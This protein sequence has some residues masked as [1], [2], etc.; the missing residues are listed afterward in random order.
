[1]LATSPSQAFWGSDR[2]R[3]RLRRSESSNSSNVSVDI[4][5]ADESHKTSTSSREEAELQ[6]LNQSLQDL[7][8][9]FPDIQPE[10]FREMLATFSRESRLHVITEAL[11]KD[12]SKFVRNRWRVGPHTERCE[13][14][15]EVNLEHVPKHETF[16]SQ[17]Y[18]AAVK[19]A[20]YEEFNSLS[21]STIKTVLAERNHSYSE[22]RPIL[23]EIDAQSW[24]SALTRF[25]TR[26]KAQKASGNPFVVL[27]KSKAGVSEP[28]LKSV[29]CSELAEE[30]EES[31]VVPLRDAQISEQLTRDEH[32]AASINHQQA[33]ETGSLLECECC[34]DTV[35][36]EN[37]L[38][39]SHDDHFVCFTCVQRTLK[40]ALF[41]QGFA[42]SVAAETGTLRCFALAPE[43]TG[44][45]LGHLPPASVR[46]AIESQKGGTDIWLKFEHKL[47]DDNL[48]A[49]RID[50]LKCPFCPYAEA[51]ASTASES[52]D[53]QP[54][55]Y[56][57]RLLLFILWLSSACL[58]I[59]ENP[60][61]L[62]LTAM[63]VAFSLKLLLQD[64]RKPSRAPEGRKPRR[65][66]FMPSQG[67][68][69]TCRNPACQKIS[70]LRC[71]AV[72]RDIH[73]CYYSSK[74][75]LRT[76]VESAISNAVKRTCPLCGL[77]FVKASGCN[78][79]ACPC[80]YKMC[81]LC[82]ADVRESG[83]SH[84]CPHFRP[85][86]GACTVCTR[87]DLYKNEDEE[88]VVRQARES[89]EKEWFENEGRGLDRERLMD[90]D[91]V[92][93]KR[94]KG[95]P[96]ERMGESGLYRAFR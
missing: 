30:L 6:E 70:C 58:A 29:A 64:Y 20:L 69:F 33:Q 68:K 77:S 40:E 43:S 82:R 57:H 60:F 17:N 23:L 10:V 56:K 75:S 96:Y 81:Y 87:C 55:A 84:F 35:T 59:W 73:Q 31:F 89:A 42:Q 3:F 32:L 45:C 93:S 37:A 47:M 7:S 83:Y 85:E 24:R 72:W 66:A 79:L 61:L 67:R 16:R 27:S 34:Y 5:P 15:A 52:Q 91:C 86:G 19:E 78:K 44:Q 50:A 92:R 2:S 94:R 80:G 39:C 62:T 11:L 21:H 41:G 25:F 36:F 38:L 4:P 90:I 95:V 12:R 63:S 48:K 13:A 76:Y 26:R 49:S 65:I 88:E 54:T 8:N 46:R 28:R 1:M 51:E 9:L 22:S 53:G 74:E 14:S 71:S 18:K